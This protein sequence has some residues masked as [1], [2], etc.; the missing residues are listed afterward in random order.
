M[1]DL[2]SAAT[3]APG[4]F[5]VRVWD[6]FVR[7]FHWSL[8]TLFLLNAAILDDESKAHELVGYTIVFLVAL[9][10]VW[11]LI[12]TRYARFSAFP[13]NVGLALRHVAAMIG[14]G[15]AQEPHLSH[16]PLGALMVYNLLASM[17]LLGL[18]GW[19]M[20]TTAFWGAEWLEETHEAIANW[21][22]LSV[23]LHVAGVAVE[24]WRSKVPLV[25]AMLTGWKMVPRK[26][27]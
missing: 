4:P 17:L 20:T 19:M 1:T 12:G 26:S 21:A 13:P 9:R 11:G 14:I 3:P 7:I 5:A 15:K 24:T 27:R 6:P 18:T 16:N 8:A 22:I 25:R 10:L 23:V 2:A